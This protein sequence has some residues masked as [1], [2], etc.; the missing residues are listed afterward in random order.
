MRILDS[1]QL[2]ILEYSYQLGRHA[3]GANRPNTTSINTQMSHEDRIEY[4][5]FNLGYQHA[6]ELFKMIDEAPEY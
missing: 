3:R 6:D 2:K 4:H 5:A 1:K